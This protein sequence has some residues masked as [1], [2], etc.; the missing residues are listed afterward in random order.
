MKD[1]NKKEKEIEKIDD[2]AENQNKGNKN[3][4]KIELNNNQIKKDEEIKENKNEIITEDEKIK[5]KENKKF[6]KISFAEFKSHFDNCELAIKNDVQNFKQMKDVSNNRYLLWL[7][8]LGILPYKSNKDWGKIISDER[9]SYH[10]YK[11]KLITK[12]IED[13]I[14][15][16]KIKDKYSLYFKFKD[17]LPKEDYNYLDIIKIDVTRTFQKIEFFQKEEIQKALI[18]ILFI[19]AKNNKDIGY[20]QGMSDLCAIFLYVIYKPKKLDPVFI[21]DNISLLFYLFYSNNEFLESD[22]YTLFSRFMKKGHT[23]FFLYNDEKYVNGQLSMIETK[24]RKFLKKEDIINSED[25]DLKKRMF[26]VYYHEFP[27]VD[28]EL[29]QFMVDKIDPE[30]IL[31]RWYL[32]F[33]S[34]EFPLPQILQFWDLILYQQFLED[35]KKKKQN[36]NEDEHY[37]IF[38]DYIVLSMLINI[39]DLLMKKKSSSELMAF[40]MKYPK[41][42]EIKNIFLKALEIYNKNKNNIKI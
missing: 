5:K 25:S 31:V 29:Y 24:N 13:F 20:R 18:N 6:F 37:F 15:T 42:I 35:N 32:C 11:K 34:R 39:R 33:F 9:V 27:L 22:T 1:N 10:E 26:L 17:I 23:N 7:L 16:K 12:D 14:I 4:I 41:N 2:K 28:K 3:E 36:K 40:L 19:F 38:S 21:E 30:I 8:F